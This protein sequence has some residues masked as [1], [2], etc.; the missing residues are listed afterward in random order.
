MA[1]VTTD[2]YSKSTMDGV[3]S[4]STKLLVSY[5]MLQGIKTE[6]FKILIEQMDRDGDN[7]LLRHG[8]IR[9][10]YSDG[11]DLLRPKNADQINVQNADPVVARKIQLK[12]RNLMSSCTPDKY[13]QLM[14]DV[15]EDATSYLA[16]HFLQP[17]NI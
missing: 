14:D 5:V 2:S 7:V 13:L 4:D 6:A 1:S 8:S 15:I 17:R 3:I 10:T 12:L 9:K 16:V 11:A